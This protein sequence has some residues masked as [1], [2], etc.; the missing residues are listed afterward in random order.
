[1][2]ENVVSLKGDPIQSKKASQDVVEE[3]EEWLERAKA[4]EIA[5][6]AI[7]AYYRDG[8]SGYRL[9]GSV[10]RSMVG[11]LFSLMQRITTFLN[12]D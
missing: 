12:D 1:M 4:G 7:A 8:S 11:Q 10:S 5:G 9:A 2:S 3:L 6:V